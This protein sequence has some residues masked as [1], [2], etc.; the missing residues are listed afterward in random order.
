MRFAILGA[1]GVGGYYAG[2]LAA[3]GLD[4]RVLARG[5]NL[6][7][8]VAS[9]VR[10]ETPD[11]AFH[12]T[13][14]ATDDA[15]ALGHVDVALITVKSFALEAVAAPAARL[16]GGGA[17]V[18]PLLNGVDA[19][20][21]L[22]A[23]GVPQ[24]RLLEGLTYISAQRI[25]PG[26]IRRTS[27]FH[28]VIVGASAGDAGKRVDDIVAAFAAA[29]C[30]TSASADIQLEL[31]RKFIFIAAMA[32][33]CG[34][35][36]T[37]IGPVRDAPLGALLLDRAVGEVAAVARA[38][39]ITLPAGEED[40]VRA[41]ID[42]LPAAMKPSFLLDLQAGGPTELDALSG[43]VVRLARAAGVSA[44][45]HETALAAFSAAG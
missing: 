20:H 17:V 22:A 40:R 33:A 21:R 37:S 5:E 27:P 42:R 19:G 12:A 32:A 41:H 24:D 34:L 9:G 25:A 28:R 14:A 16:A 29:G 38:Q 35:A 23:A 8:V 18:L 6:R 31:W 11:G 13:V 30:E 45:V 2:M 15:T 1:G 43:T 4:V 39:G 10:I 7:A 36:R 44:P 26:V 3:A